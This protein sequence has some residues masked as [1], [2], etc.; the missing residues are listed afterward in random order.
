MWHGLNRYLVQETLA[1][2]AVLC[3]RNVPTFL[4]NIDKLLPNYT[5]SDGDRILH[6]DCHGHLKSG[7]SKLR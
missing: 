3:D 1:C 7:K 2:D 4:L 6:S 5:V